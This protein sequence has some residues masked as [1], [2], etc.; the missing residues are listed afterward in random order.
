MSNNMPSSRMI[1]NESSCSFNKHLMDTERAFKEMTLKNDLLDDQIFK[2]RMELQNKNKEL[3]ETFKTLLAM[4]EENEAEKTILFSLRR[5][6]RLE[7]E[8]GETFKRKIEE[9]NQMV[10]SL[11]NKERDVIEKFEKQSAIIIEK[12]QESH[13]IN[14]TQ[15]METKVKNMKQRVKESE[16]M[17]QRLAEKI[18]TLKVQLS[19]EQN[20]NDWEGLEQVYAQLK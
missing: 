1:D 15:E 19:H 8:K 16:A 3:D 13:Q 17:K 5:T 18:K 10:E 6:V 11:Q 20:N 7:R 14:S 12:M 2:L 4:E 9:G